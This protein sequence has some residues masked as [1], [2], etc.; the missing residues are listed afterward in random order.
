MG[1][2]RL[3]SSDGG[4]LDEGLPAPTLLPLGPGSVTL[5]EGREMKGQREV[6]FTYLFLLQVLLKSFNGTTVDLLQIPHLFD[7]KPIFA[8]S[9]D[10]KL[11]TCRISINKSE[12]E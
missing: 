12:K 6:T 3:P 5:I 2:K 1:D 11:E 4:G 9:R 7:Y 10:A 8:I